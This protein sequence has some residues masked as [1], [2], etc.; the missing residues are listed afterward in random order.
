MLRMSGSSTTILSRSGW[1]TSGPVREVF[2]RAFDAAG[3]PYFN[4]HTFRDM[5]VQ[6]VISLNL[7]HEEMKAWS[8][9]LGHSGLL[10]TYTSYGNIPPER[11]REL[12]RASARHLDADSA[13]PDD[14]A[15]VAALVARLTS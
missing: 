15:L 5:L 2:Q 4:P 14:D 9:S 7:S 11:Q 10:V 13:L 12:I 3:L 6:H 8:Q 1:A